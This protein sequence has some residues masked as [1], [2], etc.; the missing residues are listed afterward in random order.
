MQVN[1][2]AIDPL[3]N[4]QRKHVWQLH[5]KLWMAPAASTWRLRTES[6]YTR[7]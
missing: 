7:L 2:V 6:K 1:A 4:G 5:T 3:I